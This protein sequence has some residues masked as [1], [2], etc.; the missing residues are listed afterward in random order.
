[1]LWKK[2]KPYALWILLVEAVGFLAALFSGGGTKQFALYA[3]K[4]PLTPPS[5]VFPVVWGILYALLGIGTARIWE[6]SESRQRSKAL[7]W[8]I[9]Q[10]VLNF[11]WTLVFF[12][13]AAYGVA[14]VWV[15]V[16]WTAVFVM[17]LQFS[18]LD[19]PAA[20]LQIPYLLW[21]TFATYLT[22]GVWL[23]NG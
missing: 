14:S 7:N 4:P 23:M 12:N 11:F 16:L 10:L 6:L 21:L 2:L 5:V 13:A 1:M 20:W 9:I 18:K 19:K 22:F 15:V 17:I 3:N 8:F